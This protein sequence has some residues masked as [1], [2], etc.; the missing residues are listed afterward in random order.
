DAPRPQRPTTPTPPP[1][2]MSQGYE[3]DQPGDW[4]DH[5]GNLAERG[6][7]GRYERDAGYSAMR[8]TGAGTDWA[9]Q[10][11]PSL[12]GRGPRNWTRSPER[13]REQLCGALADHPRVDASDIDVEV[14]AEGTV[15]LRGSVASR[16]VKYMVEDLCE[17]MSDHNQ[18]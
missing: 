2:G 8:G 13:L 12:R 10:Y 4:G 18:V 7:Y 15:T 6:S 1:V 9:R 16:R 5:G 11:E 3:R 17:G 14:D